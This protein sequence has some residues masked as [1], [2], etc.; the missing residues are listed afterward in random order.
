MIKPI[1]CRPHAAVWPAMALAAALLTACGGGSDDSPSSAQTPPATSTAPAAIATPAT[2]PTTTPAATPAPAPA[3]ASPPASDTRFDRNSAQATYRITFSGQ[4]TQQ[5]GFGNVPGPAHFS[6]IIGAAVN[7]QSAIWARG[8]L[9]TPG[10]EEVAEEGTTTAI[11]PEIQAEVNSNAALSVARIGDGRTEPGEVTSGEIE[12]T[13]AHPLY[14]FITMVA[15]SP[16]W[17]VGQSKLPMKNA[18][19]EWIESQDI[20]L[21]VYDAGTEAGNDFVLANPATTPPAPI[22]RLNGQTAGGLQFV[23]GLLNG[24]AAIATLRVER[25]R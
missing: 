7:Q 24:T 19:G 13:A 9:A 3:P 12:F 17:F 8:A 21:R 4:W 14:T 23:D 18:S 5:N 16:D 10:V 6:D 22:D 25:I 15:P 1:A 11:G 2:T 20:A